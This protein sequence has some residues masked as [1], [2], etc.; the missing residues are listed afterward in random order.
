MAP[1][2]DRPTPRRERTPQSALARALAG[3]ALFL[4]AGGTPARAQ[5]GPW[6]LTLTVGLSYSN[7]TRFQNK[8]QLRQPKG[9]V[10]QLGAGIA[11]TFLQPNGAVN[12]GFHLGG[13]L[14]NNLTELNRITTAAN[15]GYTRELSAS[16]RLNLADQFG[17]NYNTLLDDITTAG[18]LL[19]L[20]GTLRNDAVLDLDHDLSD[21]TGLG[22]TVRH[23]LFF[24]RGDPDLDPDP[25]D[26]W[27]LAGSLHLNHQFGEGKSGSASVGY[28]RNGKSVNSNAGYSAG[29][30]WS[31]GIG[32]R[33]R[34]ATGIGVSASIGEQYTAWRGTGSAAIF[35][36]LWTGSFHASYFRTSGLGL[37]L[38]RV[39]VRDGFAINLNQTLFRK[40]FLGIT[41]RQV[42]HSDP[43]D[44]LFEYDAQYVF[45]TAKV[46]VWGVGSLGTTYTLLRR[47]NGPVAS[48]FRG[49]LQFAYHKDF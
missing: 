16:T 10:A 20:E 49:G 44:S 4:L 33:F 22:F 25:I 2:C 41:A 38:G 11:H 1:S 36:Q 12:V 7:N 18:V 19:P 21:R 28:S 42:S 15:V 27:R 13:L 6:R 35:W 26:G 5:V 31:Q 23:D 37:G 39:T 46:Q 40:V 48:G 29:I 47:E 34:F 14:F 17:T 9:L 45:I 8:G 32:P 43:F 3:C 24:F 30:G